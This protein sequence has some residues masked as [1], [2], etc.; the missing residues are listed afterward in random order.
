MRVES[1]HFPYLPVTLSLH[2][3]RLEFEA[4]LD[5]GFDGGLAVPQ[6]SVAFAPST[7]LRI[8]ALLADGS[9]VNAPAYRG[10]VRIG[11]LPPVDTRIL[12]I[13]NA[14]VLGRE[15]ADQYKITLDHGKR[16]VVEP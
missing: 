12:V 11:S 10:A 4:L 13:G 7:S 14:P 2:G 8:G 1:N 5:T 6:S 9:L 15:V 3:H 16:I